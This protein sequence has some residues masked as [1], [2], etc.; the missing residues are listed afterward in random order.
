M[1]AT[2]SITVRKIPLE[3]HNALRLRAARHQHSTEAEV[4]AILEAA[5]APARRKGSI[6]EFFNT[7]PETIKPEK[8]MTIANMNAIIAAGWAGRLNPDEGQD[9]S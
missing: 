2:R 7:L 1:L 6:E 5:V 3:V 8:P 9:G 4:R